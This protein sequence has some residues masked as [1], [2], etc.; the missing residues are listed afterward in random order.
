MLGKTVLLEQPHCYTSTNVVN[1]KQER[2][3]GTEN[4]ILFR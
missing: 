3:T 4:E 1:L 2:T